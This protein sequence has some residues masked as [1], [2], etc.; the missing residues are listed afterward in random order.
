MKLDKSAVTMVTFAEAD[1][2]AKAEAKRIPFAKKVEWTTRIREYAYG[3]KATTGRLRRIHSV[4]KLG[5]S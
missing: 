3:K 2:L 5:E 4:V 1:R